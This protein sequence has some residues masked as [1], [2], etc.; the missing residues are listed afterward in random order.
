[1]RQLAVKAIHVLKTSSGT[2]RRDV[3]PYMF[4]EGT[5]DLGTYKAKLRNILMDSGA[6]HGS[7]ISNFWFENNRDRISPTCIKAI[8]GTVVMGDDETTQRVNTMVVLTVIIRDSKGKSVPFTAAFSVIEMK[9]DMI[10]GL[11]DLVSSIPVFFVQRFLLAAKRTTDMVANFTHEHRGIASNKPASLGRGVTK[12]HAER[13]TFLKATYVA[14]RPNSIA[15]DRAAEPSYADL[16]EPWQEMEH[17]AAEERDTHLPVLFGQHLAF[18]EMTEAD[19]RQEYIRVLEA[20]PPLPGERMRFH[21][22][23][24]A[25]ERFDTFMRTVAID[26]F[27]PSNWEGINTEDVHIEF[28]PL[29][30]KSRKISCR[31]IPHKR[32]EPVAKE[33]KRLCSYHLLP[34]TSS[35]VSALVVADKATDP[36]VRLCG[37]YRWV[38]TYVLLQHGWIPVVQD[39]LAQLKGFKYYID[40]DLSNAF[41][42]F[43]IDFE[44]SEVLALLTPEG[45]LRPRFL[46]EGVAPASAILQTK[47]MELFKGFD[48]WLLVIFDNCVIG[49]NSMDELMDRY[50]L[51]IARCQE[52]NIF[53]KLSK[54]YFGV[55]EVYFFGYIVD[56]NGFRFDQERLQG[57]S[58]Y[59]FPTTGT[60]AQRKTAMQQFL[61]AANFFRPAYVYASGPKS[62]VPER[63]Q[64]WTDL[65]GGLYETTNKNFNWDA[66]TYI[67]NYA[68][69]FRRLQDMLLDASKIFFPDYELPWILRTDASVQGIGAILFQIRSLPNPNKEEVGQNTGAPSVI[70]EPIATISHKFSGPATR[71]ATIKQ[72]C[73][74]IYY[75]IHKLS[76]LLTGKEFVVE[77]DHAN[78]VFLEKSEVPILTRWRLY[79]QT[80]R[81][82]IRHIPGVENVLA[83]SLSRQV[84]PEEEDNIPYELEAYGPEEILNFEE[85]SAEQFASQTQ[86]ELVS[87]ATAEDVSKADLEREYPL[88]VPEW[89][90]TIMK[91]HGGVNLHFGVDVT[92][93]RLNKLFR[94]HKIPVAYITRYVEFCGGCQKLTRDYRQNAIEPVI[95]HLRP[96]HPRETIGIDMIVMSPDS[97]GMRYAHVVMNH[98]SKFV[99]I[100]A[101]KTADAIDAARAV[102]RYRS[103]IGPFRVMMS[104]PGSNYMSKVMNELNNMLGIAHRVSLVDRHE[105]NGVEPMNQ[106][107]KRHV[108]AIIQDERF[109]D[110][111]SSPEVLDLIQHEL[112][113]LPRPQTA[114]YTA[115]EL[116]TGTLEEDERYAIELD[117]KETYSAFSKRLA[118]DLVRI[119]SASK[120]F[121]DTKAAKAK[122]TEDNANEYVEGDLVLLRNTKPESKNQAKWLGPF[123]VLSTHKNDVMVR[124]AS[125][126]REREVHVKDLRVYYGSQLEAF[127]LA[128]RDSDEYVVAAIN[129][130]GGDPM[131]RQTLYFDTTFQDDS[132]SQL[133]YDQ[134]K[135]TEQLAMFINQNKELRPLTF[136]THALAL[137]DIR[138]TNSK[139]LPAAWMNLKSQCVY[140]DIRSRDHFDFEWYEAQEFDDKLRVLHV[141]PYL[142]TKVESNGTALEIVAKYPKVAPSKSSRVRLKHYGVITRAYREQDLVDI[143]HVIITD[144]QEVH[145]L[146][147]RESAGN[148]ELSE[149]LSVELGSKL[150]AKLTGEQETTDS[151]DEL[152]PTTNHLRPI[153]PVL[154]VRIYNLNANGLNSAIDKG[155]LDNIP[156]VDHVCIQETKISASQRL[157][158]AI[159]FKA[160]GY[161]SPYYSCHSRKGYAG[162]A[163]FSRRKAIDSSEEVCTSSEVRIL[164]HQTEGR[165]LTL[166]YSDYVLVTAY[167]PFPRMDASRTSQTIAWRLL[168]SRHLSALE[169]IYPSRPIILAGDLNGIRTDLDATKALQ[170]GVCCTPD[171]RKSM[172]ELVYHSTDVYRHLHPDI[173]GHTA[174]CSIPPQRGETFRLDYILT[175]KHCT[176]LT[177]EVLDNTTLSD[178][179]PIYAHIKLGKANPTGSMNSFGKEYSSD[180]TGD[181]PKT[182]PKSSGIR[183]YLVPHTTERVVEAETGTAPELGQYPEIIA[184]PLVSDPNTV[185]PS[186]RHNRVWLIT[187]GTNAGQVHEVY[188]AARLAAINTVTQSRGNTKGFPSREL[189][190]EYAMLHSCDISPVVAESVEPMEMSHISETLS[191]RTS[192][193]PYK[194]R[195]CDQ[196]EAPMRMDLEPVSSNDLIAPI[197]H[198]YTYSDYRD[199]LVDVGRSLQSYCRVEALQIIAIAKGDRISMELADELQY[200]DN[201]YLVALTDDI[202][203]D[204]SA[205]AVCQRPE[206]MFSMA[207]NAEGLIDHTGRSNMTDDNNNAAAWSGIY[208]NVECVLLYALVDIEPYTDIMWNYHYGPLSPVATPKIGDGLRYLHA[209]IAD[210]DHRY[211]HEDAQDSAS[212]Y[213]FS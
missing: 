67:T 73:Y 186:R 213:G 140:L 98:F 42:Q 41:H 208:Q 70:Y 17:Q 156:E 10:I 52:K 103:T 147:T 190:A 148:R 157:K 96:P 100:Y 172:S 43:R 63:T 121:Q 83:D 180:V 11:P 33:I 86:E 16:L 93:K 115:M 66:T 179:Y 15:K 178:H 206:C 78:L 4:I 64:L 155:L 21:P 197:M 68:A 44:T 142:V 170:Q 146:R 127:H 191:S 182:P 14:N 5:A 88:P 81:F 72:E 109:T 8:E 196:E 74:S 35:I 194:C 164:A 59:T 207:N 118:E 77:T 9:H 181:G 7:Y 23:L 192:S 89:D 45:T 165:L 158:Y 108:Q 37:D 152:V 159:L 130:Y 202:A 204:C 13:V 61:G 90:E 174:T 79:M 123:K 12:R 85:V 205:Y 91:V 101:T 183:Q 122:Q 106:Q 69:A 24:L 40:L 97:N 51:F 54:S 162:V 201:R 150:E 1:M 34:S 211:L 94:G 3:A 153:A 104:D 25:N 145:G 22:E 62:A 57:L 49:G 99:L 163:I 32:V 128:I 120:K 50:E 53:L 189:A 65:T 173:P 2:Q 167:V 161:R 209:V 80:F 111:W 176:P 138:R 193:P 160:A 200:P 19:A 87:P 137:D 6:L 149:E 177:V 58:K 119:R 125:S 151:D 154:E 144:T 27:V 114:G 92:W 141:M 129:H 116:N 28:D 175:S 36:F 46:P 143:T 133:L 105:S 56:R 48:D 112:N 124:H 136:K 184:V 75:A 71:W 102:L 60:D 171:E 203:L 132:V 76:H 95:R 212:D 166:V 199:Q 29:M 195:P 82:S 113:N 135:D 18:M 84:L 20:P 185:R 188:E 169:E 131:R 39:A 126:Q 107:I 31:P 26:T 210:L 168:L 110:R 187:H 47:M 139:Q 198:R 55:T 38:N 30:P 117:P 134:L